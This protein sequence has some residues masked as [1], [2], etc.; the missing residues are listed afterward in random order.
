MTIK[1]YV[2]DYEPIKTPQS[3]SLQQLQE[4]IETNTMNVAFSRLFSRR[5]LSLDRLNVLLQVGEAGSIA[6]A[7][8]EDPVRQSQYSRQLKELAEFFGV[9]LTRREGKSLALT[10]AGRRLAGIVRENLAALSDFDAHCQGQPVEIVIG[11]GDS[12]IQWLLLPR[13]HEVQ[14]EFTTVTVNLRNLRT[15][16]IVKGIHDMSLDFGIVRGDAVADAGRRRKLGR[17]EYALFVPETL[18]LQHRTNEPAKMLASLPLV[19]LNLSGEL[20]RQFTAVTEKARIVPVVRLQCDSLPQAFQAVQTG[21][22]AAV[23][24]TLAKPLA[25]SLGIRVIGG[26]LFA[27]M[28]RDMDLIWSGRVE[29]V[30]PIIAQVA[31]AVEKLWRF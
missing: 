30:R 16:E 25:E 1:S 26:K 24:P 9:E 3:L 29:R 11:A 13:M 22:Y 27:G 6:K 21:H 12:I 5:G 19:S 14:C 31:A 17:L 10:Q 8:G 18:A 7:A 23:L 15:A 20:A 2:V 28:S 4:Q